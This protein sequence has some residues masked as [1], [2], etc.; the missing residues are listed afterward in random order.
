VRTDIIPGQKGLAARLRQVES[1]KRK[2]SPQV[3]TK[4]QEGSNSNGS[5][6]IMWTPEQQAMYYGAVLEELEGYCSAVEERREYLETIVNSTISLL[7]PVIKNFQSPYLRPILDPL[8]ER[9]N[10]M[11]AFMETALKSAANPEEC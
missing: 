7:R 9:L 3:P 11:A 4:G 6:G 1:Q 5:A 8:M 2:M 10:S